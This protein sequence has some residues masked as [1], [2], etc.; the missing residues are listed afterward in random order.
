MGKIVMFNN[1]RRTHEKHQPTQRRRHNDPFPR[2]NCPQTED[3]YGLVL[4]II[5][6]TLNPAAPTKTAS[7][8]KTERETMDTSAA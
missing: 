5:D 2:P 3:L 8:S 7:A 6:Y 1:P 4:A